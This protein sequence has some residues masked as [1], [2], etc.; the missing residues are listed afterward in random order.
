M[1]KLNQKAAKTVNKS[2][3]T[4]NAALA[5]ID[6]FPDLD[7]VD[8]SYSASMS[9]D[10]FSFLL[11]IIKTTAGYNFI[12][13]MLAKYIKW[14]VPELEIAVKAFLSFHIKGLLSCT[15]DPRIPDEVLRNGVVFD[16]E[17]ID[18]TD[19][20]KYCP[21]DSIGQNYYFDNVKNYEETDEE[22]EEDNSDDVYGE[23]ATKKK[24]KKSKKPIFKTADD[25]K[26]SKDFNCLLWFMKNKASFREVWGKKENPNADALS[27]NNSDIKG[28][29]FYWNSKKDKCKKTAGIVTL[30]YSPTPNGVK[31]ALGNAMA[32][33]TPFNNCLHV[34]IGNVQEEYEEQKENLQ[35]QYNENLKYIE[36]KM[37]ELEEA[38]KEQKSEEK[39]NSEFL[40]SIKQAKINPSE[41][42]GMQEII[43]DG[44][45]SLFQN[46]ITKLQN[47]I[48]E[49]AQRNVEILKKIK[50]LSSE[51]V[52]YRPLDQNY[53]YRRTLIQFNL[54][55]IWSVKL[56]DEK[57]ITAQLLDALFGI[58]KVDINLDYKRR[59]IQ[60]EVKKMVV[61]I[62]QNDTTVV[63]D[64][65]FT[66]TNDDYNAMLEKAELNR[67]N[68]FTVGDDPIPLTIDREEI[69]NMLNEISS[70]A[71]EDGDSKQI[72][73]LFSFLGEGI[74][75]GDKTQEDSVNISAYFNIIEQLLTNLAYV[76]TSVVISPKVYLLIMVNLEI[77]GQD[78]NFQLSEF[79]ARFKKLISDLIRMIR[80]MLISFILKQLQ[81][82]L[83]FIAVR[84]AR[85]IGLEQMMY[86][87]DLL[88]KIFA[89]FKR[90]SV[91]WSMDYVNY[92]DIDY[93]EDELPD[94]E[95]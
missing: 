74:S 75:Y 11:E 69:L 20:L 78:T 52:S 63:N 44:V 51:G 79:M 45:M 12:I 64:C 38:K 93:E 46:K 59:F 23:Q 16:L 87:R 72:E 76:I 21:T 65:F 26:Y 17:Q 42:L 18:I 49:R 29:D 35:K 27:T 57:V 28:V 81:Q 70:S 53:Y 84:A 66:F 89:C 83:E 6:K 61:Q 9:I 2:I 56:Y 8:S 68:L 30:E 85:I 54:D 10:P 3:S 91:D 86:Y 34:F 25:L 4:I 73:E 95:C 14:A 80:D 40:D 13:E 55:Y 62:N 22:I 60:D 47:Q 5:I 15:L 31:D 77:M 7:N 92:A 67:A 32:L 82:I 24:T 94:E 19:L 71:F 43:D 58:F 33:Q 90:K 48:D 88:L 1:K 50:N 39:K 41:A 37:K 36:E